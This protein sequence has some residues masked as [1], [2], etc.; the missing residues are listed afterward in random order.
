MAVKTRSELRVVRHTRIRKHLVG[1]TERPRLAIFKSQKHLYAQIIDDSK[2]AT[3][4]AASSAEKALSAGDNLAGAK[5]IGEALAKRAKENGLSAV[6]FDR[7][8][9]RYHGC[10]AALADGARQGGLEF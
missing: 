10:I 4:A 7:G 1:T 5:L 6:V 9:F 2:G 3:L 8:G